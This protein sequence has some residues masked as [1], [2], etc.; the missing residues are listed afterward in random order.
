[1][2]LIAAAPVRRNE[3][4]VT[5]PAS[6]PINGLDAFCFSFPCFIRILIGYK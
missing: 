3:R 4:R 5:A 2:P 1:M 6:F